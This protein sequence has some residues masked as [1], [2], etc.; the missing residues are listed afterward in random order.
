MKKE[1]APRGSV[2]LRHVAEYLGLNP[3]T[4]SVVLN[5]KPGRSIPEATRERIRAAARKLNYQPS[6]LARSLQS[7]RT[8]TIGILVPDLDDGYYTQVL[9]GIAAHLISAEYFYFTAHHGNDKQLI[10]EYSRVLLQR[11][12]EAIIAIDTPLEQ[13]FN[14]P[15]IQ[16][17]SQQC[18]PRVMSVAFDHRF[19][20]ELLLNHL[21][22]LGHRDI[23]FVKGETFAAIADEAWRSLLAVAHKIGIRVEPKLMVVVDRH[24]PSTELGYAAAQ[25]LLCVPKRFTAV[26]AFNG[27]LTI[28]VLRGLQDSGLRIP[29]DVSVVAFDNTGVAE[30]ST[31]TLTTIRHPLC[32]MGK[33]AAQC[34]LETLN[35]A[36]P[37]RKQILVKPELIIRESTARAADAR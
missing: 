32:N 20:A 33:I 23:A 19:G 4:V 13:S 36:A 29:E 25:R 17:A 1:A 35:G 11:G 31:P 21:S 24:T 3:A 7:R 27:I 28:G 15:V 18:M 9:S 22:S 26:V 34:I 10:E 8:Q 2:G 5:N 14:V 37:R 16:V 12:A 30:F 6:L